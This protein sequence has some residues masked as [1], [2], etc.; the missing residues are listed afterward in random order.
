M[1]FATGDTHGDFRRFGAKCFYE[2][3]EM[4]QDDYVIICGDFGGLWND[5]AEEQ[6]D[7]NW[8]E[9]NGSQGREDGVSR[10]TRDL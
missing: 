1:I 2:Q 10:I 7:L 5:S 4:T 8:L 3:K 9:K 6:H